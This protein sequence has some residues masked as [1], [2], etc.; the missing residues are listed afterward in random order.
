MIEAVNL[1]RFW[2][3]DAHPVAMAPGSVFVLDASRL[4]LV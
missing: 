1:L 2:L 3:R 4:F